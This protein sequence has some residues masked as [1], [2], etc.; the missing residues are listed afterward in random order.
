VLVS[1]VY[2]VVNLPSQL[3]TWINEQGTTKQTLLN[4][5]QVKGSSA[6]R[7]GK[8]VS[9]LMSLSIPSKSAPPFNDRSRF[10]SCDVPFCERKGDCAVVIVNQ[11]CNKMWYLRIISCFTWMSVGSITVSFNSF[12]AYTSFFHF[13][14]QCCRTFQCFE[15]KRIV[16]YV[17]VDRLPLG[18]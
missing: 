17:Y 10:Q 18:Q 16:T 2:L 14:R 5:T 13:C 7:T 4:Q 8:L 12:Y 6:T 1:P 11:H 15:I 3:Y 9:L